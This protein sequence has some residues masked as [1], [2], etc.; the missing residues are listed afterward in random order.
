MLRTAACILS[1]G[2]RQDVLGICNAWTDTDS[3]GHWRI[4]TGHE[5]GRIVDAS[6]VAKSR[7][8][9]REWHNADPILAHARFNPSTCYYG[10]YDLCIVTFP[11]CYLPAVLSLKDRVLVA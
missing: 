11:F 2:S 6:P 9:T 8:S 7:T 5:L 10:H 3:V 4:Q 1:I